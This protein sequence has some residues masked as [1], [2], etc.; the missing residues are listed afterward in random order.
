MLFG[1]VRPFSTEQS[2]SGLKRS[3]KDLGDT[4]LSDISGT[5]HHMRKI[6]RGLFARYA[7]RYF[8]RGG[9]S[10][11]PVVHLMLGIGILG[12]S[13]EYQHLST[14]LSLACGS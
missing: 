8:N 4:K 7:E 3:I 11:T 12:Y 10:F 5:R 9:G 1:L 2:E 13:W 6:S 14:C